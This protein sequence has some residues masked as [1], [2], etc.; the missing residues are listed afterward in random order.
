M[1]SIKN[2]FSKQT[3]AIAV[4][5]LGYFV[6]VYDLF[7]F[8]MVRQQSLRELS[9][10]PSSLIQA[11]IELL[12]LQMAGVLLGGFFWGM[13]SDRKGRVK[14]LFASILIYSTANLLNAFVTH[15]Y[16]YRILRFIAGFGLAG[17][18]G[19]AV[20]WVSELLPSSRRGMGATLIASIGICGGLFAALST[21]FLSWRACFMLGALLGYGLLFLRFKVGEPKLYLSAQSE[22]VLRG[23]LKQLFLRWSSLK[24]YFL[25]VF[26]GLP[27]WF[28]GGIIMV[29]APEFAEQLGVGDSFRMSQCFMWSFAATALGD[30]SCGCLSQWLKSRRKVLCLSLIFVFWSILG[31]FAFGGRSIQWFYGMIFLISFGTGYWAVLVS[32]AA[33]QFGTNLRAT[34]TT[35]VPN[36]VRGCVI[37]LTLVFQLISQHQSITQTVIG[38]NLAICLIALCSV[39]YLKETFTRDLNFLE[40]N[41]S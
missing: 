18:L 2:K 27:V 37:P 38:M 41:E 6:D 11:G 8:S 26:I 39:L 12:N 40:R 32:F 19:I 25:L 16:Q 20:T 22:R 31:L 36:V 35:S 5:A 10:S 13:I 33:E 4:G 17:E 15:F 3:L 24:R 23:S 30:F 14:V 9:D 7:I 1:E 34:V 21:E 28:V 29:F